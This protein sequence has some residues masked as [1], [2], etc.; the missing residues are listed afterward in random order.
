[1]KGIGD[2]CQKLVEKKKHTTYPLVFVLLKLILVLPV[3]MATDERAFSTMKY[4]KSNLCIRIDNVFLYDCMIT[5]VESDV[6]QMITTDTI[7]RHYQT[8]RS[9]KQEL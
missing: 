9:H 2:L 4:I 5:I 1:M 7:I 3:V 6:F 8:M